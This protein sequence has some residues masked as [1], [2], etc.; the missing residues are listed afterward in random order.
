MKRLLARPLALA[1]DGAM[2]G[3][4][5]VLQWRRRDLMASREELDRY[6]TACSAFSREEFFRAPLEPEVRPRGEFVEWATPVP[7]GFPENDWARAR[8]HRTSRRG[9]APPTVLLLHALMSTSDAGYRRLAA[10]FNRQG[11]NAVF[12]HLPFHYSRIPRGFFNGELAI[13]PNLVRNGETIRQGVTELRQL[14]AYLRE[15][16]SKEFALIG[17]SYGGW[18]G[19]LLS[20]L[21]PDLRFVALIQPIVNVEHAIWKNP[22]AVSIRRALRAQ[23]ITA[24][25]SERHSHLSSPLHGVPLC[26]AERAVIT[27][28]EYDTVSPISELRDLQNRWPGSTLLKVPQG[29]F[30]YA[31]MK[32]TLKGIER[33]L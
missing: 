20:F 24:G 22:S 10:W 25:E 9:V 16:G 27:A 1:M 31:A 14:I 5:N 29:H 7:S 28:G 19:A 15:Q 12:P 17:T 21:E 30:G 11:W 32:E 6:L 8:L 13:S 18:L 33:F 23:G 26:G 3:M 2:C 4:M